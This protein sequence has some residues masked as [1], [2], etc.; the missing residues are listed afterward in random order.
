MHG[1]H[2]Y[3]QSVTN[4][5]AEA[6]SE[7]GALGTA[8]SGRRAIVQIPAEILEQVLI[9]GDLKSLTSEQRVVYYRGTCASL[10]LNYLTKPFEY[11][12]LNGKLQLYALKN[13]TDQI[14]S[15]RHIDVK[16][17]SREKIDD[18]YIVTARATENLDRVDMR[19]DESIGAVSI[20]GK[21][22]DEL[23]NAFMKAETKAKRRAT[24]SLCG[25]GLLDET[26]IETV[27]DARRVKVDHATGE[28]IDAEPARPQPSRPHVAAAG[29]VDPGNFQNVG[30]LFNAA[31]GRWR[32]SREQVLSDLN[33]KAPA[34][35]TPAWA[36]HWATL[37]AIHDGPS[38]SD[39]V[40]GVP[41]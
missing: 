33:V 32:L 22:G 7:S 17:I 3:I 31:L 2:G 20:A 38:E 11:I 9:S 16:I 37:C 8:T 24:L 36:E 5:A 21:K 10:G 27:K 41:V 29:P 18:L 40:D 28:I 34:D 4:R 12:A 19:S 6:V 23:A 30:H 25:L 39:P 35:L 26:E 15:Q 1:G 14:R 13:A